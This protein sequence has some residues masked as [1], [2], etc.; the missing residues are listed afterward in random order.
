VHRNAAESKIAH[1]AKEIREGVFSSAKLDRKL[2]PDV[3]FMECPNNA[4]TDKIVAL[5][6]SGSRK[7]LS[8]DPFKDVIVLCPK[9]D[10]NAGT[11]QLNAALSLANN[12]HGRAISGFTRGYAEKDEPIPRVG[13][14]VM[15]TENDGDNDVSNGDV[16]TIIDAGPDPHNA[17]KPAVWIELDSGRTVVLTMSD[18]QRLILAYAITG[19]KSQG[20]QYPFVLMPMTMD[21]KNMLDKN[22]VYTQWTRAKS[23]LMMVGDKEALEYGVNN[24]TSSQRRTRLQEFLEEE[25]AKIP[26]IAAD[27]PRPVSTAPRPSSPLSS[28]KRFARISE[29]VPRPSVEESKPL[30]EAVQAVPRRFFQRRP[31]PA[32]AGEH[33]EPQLPT[34]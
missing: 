17:N 10:G 5:A 1:Y 15:L 31:M 14:R 13:D 2:R 4:I 29:E 34:P 12:K 3:A 7:H 30:A 25:L 16:G 33:D 11:R 32:A 28:D 8:L 26:A 24:V 23:F 21:H 9:K 20:S 6:S 19:H 27:M 22:L 18:A